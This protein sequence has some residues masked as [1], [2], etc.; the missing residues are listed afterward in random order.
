MWASSEQRSGYN[1]ERD[2]IPEGRGP[3]T[4]S[5]RSPLG[6]LEEDEHTAESEKEWSEKKA[7]AACGGP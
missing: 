3:G 5:W 2:G 7:E 1:N 6:R 4:E